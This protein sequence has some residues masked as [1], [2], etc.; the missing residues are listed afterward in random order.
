MKPLGD[1]V[2]GPTDHELWLGPITLEEGDDSLWLDVVQTAPTENWRY[3]YALVSFITDEGAE[4]GTTKIYGNL[5]G[6]V[7]RLGI[8]RP[9]SVRTG[10]IRFVSRPYNLNWLS[11]KGAPEWN[12]S[13]RWESGA[14]GAGAPALGTRATL[15]VLADLVGAGVAY[16]FGSGATAGFATVKLLPPG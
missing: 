15:G 4:L 8:R 16:A 11:A 12:L 9:P 7:F 14:S 10:R 3:S 6:E 5:L 13:F 1:L 2:I